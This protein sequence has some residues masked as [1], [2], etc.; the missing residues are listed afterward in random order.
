[1]LGRPLSAETG[2]VFN[3]SMTSSARASSDGEGVNPNAFAVF[4]LMIISYL[5]GN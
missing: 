1:M 3:Y 2:H 5:I 4:M